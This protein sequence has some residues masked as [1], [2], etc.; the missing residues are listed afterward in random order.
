MWVE[1]ERVGRTVQPGELRRA[2]LRFRLAS[3]FEGIPTSEEQPLAKYFLALSDGERRCDCTFS[4][5]GVCPAAGFTP[6]KP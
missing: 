5:L 3:F 2:L 6:P 1:H 4:V